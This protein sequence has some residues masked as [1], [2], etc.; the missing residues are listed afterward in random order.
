MSKLDHWRKQA[1]DAMHQVQD[2]AR[3][4]V[5]FA[6]EIPGKVNG[7]LHDPN[8]RTHVGELLNADY[9]KNPGKGKTIGKFAGPIE[10]LFGGGVAFSGI[11]DLTK[12]RTDEEKAEQG[13]TDKLAP[14]VKILA[15]LGVMVHGGLT[16]VK[17]FNIPVPGITR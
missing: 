11:Q 6:Q 16:A 10:V 8:L 15:G 4:A 12:E 14:A 3:N 1:S 17:A 13:L 9:A 5:H 7:A 2:R